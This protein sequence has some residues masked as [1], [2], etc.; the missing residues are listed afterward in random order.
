MSIVVKKVVEKLDSGKVIVEADHNNNI[1]HAFLVDDID[2][3][4]YLNISNGSLY[5]INELEALL[6]EFSD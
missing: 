3:E 5:G 2:V 6:R 1:L 4:T